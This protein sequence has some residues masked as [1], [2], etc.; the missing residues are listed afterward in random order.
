MS[1]L[2]RPNFERGKWKDGDTSLGWK[3][4]RTQCWKPFPLVLT[5]VM[6]KALPKKWPEY[7][8]PF[9]VLK[10]KK[11]RRMNEWQANHCSMS[12]YVNIIL[13]VLKS[14]WPKLDPLPPLGLSFG[15][16]N[17]RSSLRLSLLSGSLS[18]SLSF[19]KSFFYSRVLCTGSAA[20]VVSIV[21]GTRGVQYMHWV[22]HKC[23]MV[24][25]KG[26]KYT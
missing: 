18:A 7:P 11:S 26:E 21:S 2:T 16:P 15:M 20:G 17:P 22:M 5:A 13:L 6:T 14:L 12:K 9:P 24:K 10:L 1:A 23:I 19:L 25:V 8:T 3:S 4:Y